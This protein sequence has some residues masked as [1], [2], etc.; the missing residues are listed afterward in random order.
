MNLEYK[1]TATIVETVSDGYG[2][3]RLIADQQ[4]VNCTMLQST[5]FSR[6]GT[7]QQV[8]SDATCYVD[9]TNSFVVANYNRLE[10]FYIQVSLYNSPQ[11]ISWYKIL[12]V[13][14]NRDHLLTNNID[15]IELALKKTRPVPTVS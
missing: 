6:N 12:R 15:N 9:P 1:D 7:I 11:N 13:T 5:S 4:T 8:E 14:V 10:G 2:N 3:Q